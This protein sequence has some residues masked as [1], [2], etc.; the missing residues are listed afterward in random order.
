MRCA[1]IVCTLGPATSTA[2]AIRALVDAGMD[3][4]RLNLSHGTYADHEQVYAMVR[5]AADATGRGVG[6]LM[7]LQ[8]PKIR[9]G[10][11]SAGPVHLDVGQRFTITT[12]DIDGDATGCSTTY[13]GL[14]GDVSCR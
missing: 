2:E 12:D 14:P 10:S 4:A 3:V 9:L 8:G 11:F 7:D 5:D 13:T 1:K 6:V